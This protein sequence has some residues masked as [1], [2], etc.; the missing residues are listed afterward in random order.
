MSNSLLL[1]P[2]N[3]CT[4]RID[5][6]SNNCLSPEE[7]FLA[8]E[9]KLKELN[10][11]YWSCDAKS[12]SS[13][14]LTKTMLNKNTD[15]DKAKNLDNDD[16]DGEQN[17]VINGTGITQGNVWSRAARR[18]HSLLQRRCY[19]PT[20]GKRERQNEEE[21]LNK[22]H[23]QIDLKNDN[24]SIHSRKRRKEDHDS[25]IDREE[26]ADTSTRIT[27]DNSNNDYDHNNT[28]DELN[29]SKE[30]ETRSINMESLFAFRINIYTEDSSPSSPTPT[31]TTTTT[32]S[33]SSSPPLNIPIATTTTAPSETK[34]MKPKDVFENNKSNK[35]STTTT[36]RWLYGH[37]RIVFESFCGMM[38]R[39]LQ[40]ACNS[41]L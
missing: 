17:L 24:A 7:M 5:P 1:P 4:I 10:M 19:S 14:S 26:I 39:T 22:E 38:R 29:A 12:S 36:I 31:T 41:H 16:E 35:K 33:S 34:T 32:T 28:K 25:R 15:F 3:E 2:S 23:T 9:R 21:D 20:R 40:S 6:K 30:N 27:N 8:L 11:L 18:R 13:H 37:D